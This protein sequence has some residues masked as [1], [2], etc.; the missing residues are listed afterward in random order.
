MNNINLKASEKEKYENDGQWFKDVLNYYCPAG[1]TIVDDAREMRQLYEIVNMDLSSIKEKM[2]RFCNPIGEFVQLQED[3]LDPLPDLA[4]KIDVLKGEAISRNDLPKVIL[5]TDRAVKEKNDQQMQLIQESITEKVALEIQSLRAQMEGMPQEEA[6]QMIANLRSKYEPEDIATKDWLSD[7]EIFY[8]KILKRSYLVDDLKMLFADTIADAAIADRFYV[9][10][11]WRHG[12]PYIEVRNPLQGQ[13]HKNPNEPF[14]HKGSMFWYR[15]ALT[16]TDAITQYN[17][18]KEDVEK[19]FSMGSSALDKRHG[20][21]GEPIVKH[22]LD[23]V[24]LLVEPKSESKTA[25]LAQT[26]EFDVRRNLV[27]ETH[28]EFVAYKSIYFLTYTNEYG[29]TVTEIVPD[30]FEIPKNAQKEKF[31]NRFDQE[32]KRYIWVDDLGYEYIAEP[33]YIPRLYEIVR[34]GNDFYP[35]YREVPYQTINVENP[36]DIN[37]STKGIVFNARN[38]KSLS[39][40][41]RAVYLYLQLLYLKYVQNTELAN[42]QGFIHSIDVD[43]IPDD[44]GL[45]DDNGAKLRDKVATYLAVLKKTHRDFYSGTQTNLGGLPPSTRSP[46]SNGFTLGTAVELMNLQQ[47]IELVKR[48][49]SLAMGIA[50]QREAS[51]MQG[52]NVSDNQNAIAQSYTITEPLFYKHS[53]VWKE[54]L[55]DYLKAYRNYYMTTMEVIGT[56]EISE[57]IWLPDGSYETLKVTPKHLSHTDIGL[58]LQPGGSASEY[59]RIMMSQAQA[60]AQN[61]GDG[62]S[63]LSQ[64]VKD[65]ANGASPEEVHKRI[66]LLEQESFER[67]KQ[68]QEQTLQAQQAMLEREIESRED[69]QSHQ[70]YLERVKGEIGLAKEGLRATALG[71]QQDLNNNNVPDSVDLA[72]IAIKQQSLALQ[73]DELAHRKEVDREKLKIARSK[74]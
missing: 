16:I 34:L 17:L 14:V 67:Q 27:W 45:F 24:E 29:K 64:L 58:L 42:Y 38:A 8:N 41:K 2:E 43:Q 10:N 21:N 59:A 70:V 53:L 13:G 12:K 55:N 1:N 39:L 48:E 69:M 46:G 9:Y 23:I 56:E 25:G 37:L 33:M 74:K 62:M 36:F 11:G 15:Q 35:I 50:P 3:A 22:N 44:L 65:I 73:R 66:L 61:Q 49:L 57:S 71:A 28:L 26:L 31:I 5:L 72:N 18:S 4:I 60:F 40:V 47:L 54:V 20:L 63:K 51:F 52:S 32:S 68:L 19:L 30:S 7:L 6:R